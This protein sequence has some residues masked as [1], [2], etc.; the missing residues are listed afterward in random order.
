MRAR[1]DDNAQADTP[2]IPI[3]DGPHVMEFEWR[4]SSGPDAL[5]G[6]LELWIDGVSVATLPGLDN[7]I[8]AVDF[9]R[10][11]ALSVKAG[12]SGSMYWDEFESRRVTYIGL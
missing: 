7:S 4:R 10:L 12:A 11:G 8:S 6:S 5:D 3:T 2:F 9:V 1:L